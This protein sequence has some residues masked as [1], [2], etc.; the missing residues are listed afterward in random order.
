MEWQFSDP[1]NVAV[2]SSRAIALGGEQI[3]HVFHDADDG[4]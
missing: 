1:P 2:I 4:G 3:L